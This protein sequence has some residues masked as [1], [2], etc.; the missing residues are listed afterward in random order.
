M[1][2]DLP[3]ISLV[4]QF[5]Q[6]FIFSACLLALSSF[7]HG[8]VAR[9]CNMSSDCNSLLVHILRC[10]KESWEW[11]E[12]A[13]RSWMSYYF[14]GKFVWN[15]KCSSLYH[16]LL[17]TCTLYAYSPA[18]LHQ[19]CFKHFWGWSAQKQNTYSYLLSGFLCISFVLGYQSFGDTGSCDND[20]AHVPI[21]NSWPLCPSSHCSV[22]RNSSTQMQINMVTT[23][24]SK[25]MRILLF[26]TKRSRGEHLSIFCW[27]LQ[28]GGMWNLL[29][30]ASM[31]VMTPTV[32]WNWIVGVPQYSWPATFIE[33]ACFTG[34]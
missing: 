14:H 12:L 32:D 33:C 25:F 2:R 9:A 15:E 19:C 23:S 10:F 4:A 18:F 26:S 7:S 21:L 11:L 31:R 5:W 13:L 27:F 17:E 24:T 8:R 16:H 22:E 3:S 29:G 30:F 28:W 34:M 1:N 20:C 6:A